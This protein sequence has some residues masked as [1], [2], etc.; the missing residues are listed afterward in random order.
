MPLNFTT[1]CL[2]LPLND[3]FSFGA[4]Q[5]DLCSLLCLEKGPTLPCNYLPWGN[6]SKLHTEPW[7]GYRVPQTGWGSC[8]STQK[9]GN[10]DPA[11]GYGGFVG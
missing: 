11:T 3:P 7:E 4:Q 9:E 10:T 1:K 6:R 5:A 2:F 8:C